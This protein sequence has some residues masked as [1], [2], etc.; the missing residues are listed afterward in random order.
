MKV[1][2]PVMPNFFI[3]DKG[4]GTWGN[5]IPIEELTDSELEQIGLEWTVKLIDLANNLR[6]KKTLSSETKS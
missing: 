4:D 1:V 6:K 2:S 5:P 3:E